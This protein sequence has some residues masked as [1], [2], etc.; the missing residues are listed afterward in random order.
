MIVTDMFEGMRRIQYIHTA[1][2]NN[3]IIT[4][5][6]TTAIIIAIAIIIV[7][8]LNV[9]INIAASIA[10]TEVITIIVVTCTG[11]VTSTSIMPID[12]I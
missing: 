12:W 10:T 1:C 6:V 2:R 3:V 9:L 11:P 7:I 8:N 4:V 5:I